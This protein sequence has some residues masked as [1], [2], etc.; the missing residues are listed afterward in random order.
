MLKIIHYRVVENLLQKINFHLL[1]SNQ[2]LQ[3]G[4]DIDINKSF[5]Q[6]RNF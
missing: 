6:K 3:I 1:K 4:V 5:V 2:F